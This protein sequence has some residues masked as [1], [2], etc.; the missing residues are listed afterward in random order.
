[1]RV[2]L[3][4]VL[5]AASL[6]AAADEH[7]TRPP[8][9]KALVQRAEA[10]LSRADADA[11]LSDFERAA[12]QEHALDIELG[13][14]RSRMQ[15]GEY[16]RALAFAAHA[17]GGHA[18]EPEGAAFYAALL[19][20]GGQP[21]Q[22]RRV[23]REAALPEDAGI[24]RFAP[25]ASGDVPPAGTR[26]LA[27]GLLLDARRALV[28]SAA[29]GDRETVWLRDGLGHSARADRERRAGPI[30]LLHLQQRLGDASPTL[31]PRDAFP[32]SPAHA[33][34][35]AGDAAPSWPTLHGGFLGMAQLGIEMPGASRGGPVFDA[36]GRVIGLSV[37]GD[38][39]RDWLLPASLLRQFFVEPATIAP[40]MPLDELYEQA[41]RVTLQ[42]LGS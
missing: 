33:L 23:L 25:A 21:E 8:E 6:G 28:P 11:A 27:S 26:L 35:Y 41:L 19:R 5:A 16:R 40:R 34:A 29:L 42:V 20:V 30:A 14:V 36:Q 38:D 9:R 13:I 22:A 4:A 2:L 39:G 24:E 1:M 12:N 31:A 15:Q 10:A 17:A 18:D 7:A 37:R 32:G 3:T